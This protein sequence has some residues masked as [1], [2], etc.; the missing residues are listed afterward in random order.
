MK[1]MPKSIQEERYRWI[2]PIFE[3]NKKIKSMAEDSPFSERTLKRWLA[4]YRKD[5]LMGLVPKST[6]PKTNPK[7]TSIRIKERII[8]LRKKEDCCAKK[9]AWKLEK[10]GINIHYQTIQKQFFLLHYL[11]LSQKH[12]QRQYYRH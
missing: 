11:Y 12:L 3:R 5:G 4:S 1:T 2:S 10:E 7:E 8:E 9:L 6:R